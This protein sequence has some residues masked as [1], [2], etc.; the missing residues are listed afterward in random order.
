M[1]TGLTQTHPQCCCDSFVR[2]LLYFKDV[3]YRLHKFS[4]LF[5]DACKLICQCTS[6]FSWQ[7]LTNI[8][9]I[10]LLLYNATIMLISMHFLVCKTEAFHNTWSPPCTPVAMLVAP[11]AKKQN[12]VLWHCTRGAR[13]VFIQMPYFC[14]NAFVKDCD[15]ISQS[16]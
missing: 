8:A 5:K 13:A 12:L 9:G 2:W 14:S 15:E 4:I 7:S 6:L 16:I 1:S 3:C 11:V 10:K